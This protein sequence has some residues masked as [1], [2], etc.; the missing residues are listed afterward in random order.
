MCKI[1]CINFCCRYGLYVHSDYRTGLLAYC[2]EGWP[3]KHTLK[4]SIKPFW[5]ARGKLTV[6]QEVLLNSSRIMIPSALRLDIL[7]KV[8]EGHQGISKCRERA[9]ISIWWQGL[10]QQIRDMVE[11]C[12]ICAKH[13]QQRPQP[14]IPTGLLLITVSFINLLKELPC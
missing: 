3:D 5:S 14:L 11:N 4:D 6:I 9:K 1:L 12:R 13:K 2:L 10:S 8:H 7:D